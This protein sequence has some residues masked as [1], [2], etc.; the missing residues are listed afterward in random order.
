MS[1]TTPRARET[2]KWLVASMSE[3][4]EQRIDALIRT[5]DVT[6]AAKL[7]GEIRYLRG[8]MNELSAMLTTED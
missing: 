5:D 7:R 3:E 4:C 8:K 2:L 6:Q 1:T